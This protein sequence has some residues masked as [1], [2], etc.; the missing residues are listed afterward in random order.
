MS[1]TQWSWLI[2]AIGALCAH[3]AIAQ[4]AL[5]PPEPQFK[6]KIGLSVKDSVPDWPQRVKAPEGAPN[7]VLIMLD[8]VGF[9]D[10]SVFGGPIETPNLEKLAA[11]GLRYN[12]FHTAA[13]CSPTRA[14]LLS[15]RNHHRMGFG[16]VGQHGYPGYNTIWRKDA[17]SIPEVLRRNGYSTA[18]FGKWHL[19]P[20]WEINPTGPF[21]RWPTGL[22]F[23]YFFGI[24]G[25]GNPWRNTQRATLP[26]ADK[27]RHLT[28]ILVDDALAWVQQQATFAPTR[29]YLLYFAPKAVH[30]PHHVGKEW[31]EKY[32][33]EFDQGWDTLREET[34]A[35]QKRLGVIPADTELTQ[36]PKELP[37]WS[38]LSPDA[39]RL[40]ARQ[41]EVYAGFLEHTDHEIGRLIDAVRSGPRGG[42]TLILYIIGDNGAE[43]WAGPY[44]TDDV[45][46]TFKNS[47]PRSVADQLETMDTLGSSGWNLYSAGWAWASNTPFK[48]FK[49]VASHFGGTRN[50]LIV[51]WPDRIKDAGGLRSQF[52][53]VNDVAATLYQATRVKFPSSVDGVT[54]Q[55]LDGPGF[56]ETFASA[57]APERHHVQYFEQ[58][59]NRAIYHDGWMA[60]SRYGVLWQRVEDGSVLSTGRRATRQELEQAPWELYHVAEDF[61]QAHDLASK[62]PERLESLKK[63]FESEATDNDVYPLDVG[64][65]GAAPE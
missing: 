60:A 34:F 31:I 15:G 28:T 37:A 54:Q 21:D 14:A 63:L 27:G 64:I 39:K 1:L 47:G 38:T 7:I 65:G 17:V 26:E 57:S 25:A 61:S 3:L 40:L 12:R 16:I 45:T 44:G 46:S 33:G 2:G 41:M 55:P 56:F 36:R 53:H 9:G 4:S 5:P 32:R 13:A 22:G 58:E 6:G 10:A 59:A 48:W 35:R 62:H 51:S 24:M 49:H 42:N 50:P 29:P 18:A 23:E 20:S 11:T 8:D 52:T 43:G 19:T 30:S